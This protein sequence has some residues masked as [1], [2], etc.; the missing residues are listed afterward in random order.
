M[1]HADH[2]QIFKHAISIDLYRH[3]HLRLWKLFYP[4][5]L[6]NI[7]KLYT[8]N[9]IFFKSN[10]TFQN[11]RNTLK[12]TN[13]FELMNIKTKLDY[14]LIYQINMVFLKLC[15]RQAL[16]KSRVIILNTQIYCE[17]KSNVTLVCLNKSMLYCLDMCYFSMQSGYTN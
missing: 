10:K 1:E 13:I 8:N 16:K 9:N 5:L 14:H 17:I 15:T 7:S 6:Y 4:T 3:H 2:L 12:L 11:S